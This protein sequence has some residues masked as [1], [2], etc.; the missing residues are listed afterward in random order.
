MANLTD[1]ETEV[2]R[3]IGEDLSVPDNWDGTDEVRTAIADALQELCAI[4]LFFV[5]KVSL[6]LQAGVSLYSFAI[7][8]YLPILIQRAV[9]IEEDRK[10]DCVSLKDLENVDPTWLRTTGS[11]R[12]FCPFNHDQVLIYP[13]YA[14]DGG[15]VEMDVLCAP[16]IYTAAE[17]F[18][19]ISHEYENALIHYAKYWLLLRIPGG[20][21]KAMY[22]FQQ[23]ILSFNNVALVNH[24]KR[25]SEERTMGGN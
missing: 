7:S 10:L 22:E 8:G 12:M 5:R 25:R 23:Y 24:V 19:S 16:D 17:M 21:Q 14:A 4:N 2:L 13:L 15:L 11:P 18:Q 9:L 1:I 6:P 3:Q 20:F